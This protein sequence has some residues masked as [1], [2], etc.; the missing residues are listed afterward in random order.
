[1]WRKVTPALIAL[2]LAACGSSQTTSSSTST[3]ASTHSGTAN[4]A[5]TPAASGPHD[6]AAAQLRLAYAGTDGATGHLEI[7]FA[8]RN[9]SPTPCRLRGY[10]AAR[11]LSKSGAALPLRVQHGGGFFPDSQRP[12]RPVIVISGGQA[13]FGVSFVTNNEYAHARTCRTAAGVMSAAPAS[14]GHWW[15]LSLH[16]APRIA[17]CGDQLVVSP[18]HA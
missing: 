8:L 13:R 11:L 7:T 10:P 6:C 4:R 14:P 5:S 17:P 18:I 15:R 2:T 3:T 12:P 9:V 1:M 16:G